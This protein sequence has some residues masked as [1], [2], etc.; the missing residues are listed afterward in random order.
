MQL[1]GHCY[2]FKTSTKRRLSWLHWCWCYIWVYCSCRSSML[3]C[4]S[5]LQHFPL[6]QEKKPVRR[7]WRWAKK[8]DSFC[9]QVSGFF[10]DNSLLSCTRAASRHRL[11]S[12]QRSKLLQT[13]LRPN[14]WMLS[15]TSAIVKQRWAKVDSYLPLLCFLKVS[16]CQGLMCVSCVL[17][18]YLQHLSC[19]NLTWSFY[20]FR[21]SPFYL[22]LF[23]TWKPA[24]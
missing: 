20:S 17:S 10:H 16:R 22:S 4:P 5:K 21:L 14:G 23:L 24:S 9:D 6:K 15:Y 13:H 8:P 3:H 7:A 1:S 18:I 11:S 2:F 19:Q 12:E